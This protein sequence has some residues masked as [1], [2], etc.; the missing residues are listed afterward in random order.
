MFN[1]KHKAISISIIN[2]EEK[3]IIEFGKCISWEL[4]LPA[5]Q[6]ISEMVLGSVPTFPAKFRRCYS[7]ARVVDKSAQTEQ[8][9]A[10]RSAFLMVMAR[11]RFNSSPS[12]VSLLIIFVNIL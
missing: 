10:R 7:L 8:R 12:Y 5:K 6:F 3:G 1:Y 9:S 4:R 11:A 2:L